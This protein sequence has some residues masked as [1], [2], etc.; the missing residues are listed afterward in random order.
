MGREVRLE[1][2]AG[3][4]YLKDK[5]ITSDKEKGRVI[6]FKE[7][8]DPEHLVHVGWT[9]RDSDTVADEDHL[10]VFRGECEFKLVGRSRVFMLKVKATGEKTFY[11]MQ[12]PD[13]SGDEQICI[14]VNDIIGAPPNA[15]LVPAAAQCAP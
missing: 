10:Y 13:S 14:L 7:S 12:D 8:D 6:L 15:P 3:K 1:F 11:W 5:K 2:K 4:S 9:R